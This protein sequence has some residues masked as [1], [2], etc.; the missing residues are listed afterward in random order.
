MLDAPLYDK[1]EI[2][3]HCAAARGLLEARNTY[4]AA[5]TAWRRCP[6]SWADTASDEADFLGQI[7]ES[8][9]K[10]DNGQA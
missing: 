9:E 1:E 8:A 6:L 10:A 7:L 4:V 2:A 3:Q 5:W